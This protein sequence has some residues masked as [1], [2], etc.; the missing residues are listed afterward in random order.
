MDYL[1]AQVRL[2]EFCLNIHLVDDRTIHG[3]LHVMI[4]SH[5]LNCRIINDCL[6]F[7]LLF[8]NWLNNSFPRVFERVSIINLKVLQLKVLFYLLRNVF[9]E[10][11]LKLLR[12]YLSCKPLL[13]IDFIAKYINIFAFTFCKRLFREHLQIFGVIFFLTAP[14]FDN[15]DG[16][17]KMRCPQ[18]LVEG[19]FEVVND[20]SH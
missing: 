14:N 19:I 15:F 9:D 20:S 1:A 2:I 4:S 8:D 7:L 11:I 13:F 6:F 18:N 12:K 3:R 10:V 16:D 17:W 5:S